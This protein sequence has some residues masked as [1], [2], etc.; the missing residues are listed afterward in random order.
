MTE[1]REI[2]P[3][4]RPVSGTIRPPGSKSLTNRA[5]VVA[6]LA[7]GT[8]HLTGVLDSRDT[9]VM[10]DSQAILGPYPDAPEGL[11]R[12]QGADIYPRDDPERADDIEGALGDGSP[13]AQ[14]YGYFARGVGPETATPPT[15]WQDRLVAVPIP[16]RV[17]SERVPVAYCLEPHDLVLAKCA[18]GRER[19][20]EF[21]A[22]AI[23]AGLVDIE[24]LLQ[25]V[26]QVP[27][28]EERVARIAA[29]L[30]AR[31]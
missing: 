3:V 24:I 6:A 25:R 26:D 15:G 10:I 7:E 12:S 9:F 19:D 30:R 16:P 23:A 8:S 5:L 20:W 22:E 2:L 18:A 1:V 21:A 11:L 31:A 13:F 29:W 17:G 28:D 4:D 14:T 27:V